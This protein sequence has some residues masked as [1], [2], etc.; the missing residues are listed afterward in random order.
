[1]TCEE[2]LMALRAGNALLKE[3]LAAAHELIAQL[4]ERLNKLEERVAKD[5]HTSSK[6]PSS[7]WYRKHRY[8]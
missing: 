2:E 6:P 7:L 3:E 1:M 8:L 5:G 4:S